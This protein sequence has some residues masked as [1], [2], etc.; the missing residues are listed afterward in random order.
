MLEVS[1]TL[2]EVALNWISENESRIIEICDKIWEFAELGLQEFKS[3]SLIADEIDKHGFRIKRGVAG[4]PTAFVASYGSGKPVIGITDQYDALPGMSQ[5]PIA[6]KEPLVPGAPGHGCGHNIH[7]AS[8]MAAAIATKV[9]MEASKIGG[10]IKFFGC[11]AEENVGGKVFMVR[12]CVFDGVDAVLSHHPSTMNVASLKSCL[13]M[14]SVKFHFYGVSAHAAASPEQGRSAVDAVELMNIGVNY[15]REHILQEARIH[16]VIEDGGLQPNI[17]PANARSW[18]YIRAPKRDQV[19]SI[20][21]RVLDIAKGADLMAGTTH[22]IGFT[23]GMYNKIPN[24][25]LSE[26]VT[27]NMR[28]IGAPTYT[29][30]DQKFAR[31]IAKTIGADQKRAALRKSKRPGFEKLMDVDLDTS[32]VDAWDEGDVIAGSSDESDVSWQTPLMMFNTAA[33]VLGTP[34][35][36]WQSTAQSGVGLG[37]KSLIFGAKTLAASVI[38][39]LTKP[40]TLMKAREEFVKRTHDY[41]YTSPLPPGLKSPFDTWKR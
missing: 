34:Y 32:I 39:L 40:N 3:S 10:T 6:K 27:T 5:K 31:D 2:K 25:T 8:G 22:K 11:P 20:Y 30:E 15:L 38:D 37:H 36:S 21:K 19:D 33:W 4:M 17:V 24:R 9:A 12:D 14:N 26:L 29:D 18:Y 28:D 16:Y 35:H 1:L 7:G 13:A 23:G 41:V